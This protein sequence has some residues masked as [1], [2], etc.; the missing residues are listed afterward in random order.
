MSLVVKFGLSSFFLHFIR[1]K[2]LF[3]LEHD[4]VRYF[5]DPVVVEVTLIRNACQIFACTC[6]S[7][8]A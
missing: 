6:C 1:H 8:S 5:L 4:L 7:S 2:V 3:E